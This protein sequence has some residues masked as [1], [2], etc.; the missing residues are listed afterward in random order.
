MK[1]KYGNFDCAHDP[2]ELGCTSWAMCVKACD[3]AKLKKITKA[4]DEC[5]LKVRAKHP[6]GCRANRGETQEKRKVCRL[7]LKCRV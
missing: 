1:C 7:N 5:S 3:Y 2:T 4:P 6:F